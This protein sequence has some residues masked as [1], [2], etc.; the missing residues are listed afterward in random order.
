MTPAELRIKALRSKGVRLAMLLLPAEVVRVHVE[1][2]GVKKK[3]RQ[4]RYVG[5]KPMPQKRRYAPD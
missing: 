3:F 1:G 5:F 2:Q 4:S